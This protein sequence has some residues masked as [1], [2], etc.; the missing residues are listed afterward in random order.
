MKALFTI[1]F[2]L[3]VLLASSDGAYVVIND[4]QYPRD[5]TEIISLGGSEVI[6]G[7]LDQFAAT[8]GN[9]FFYVIMSSG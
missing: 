6:M 5:Y 8:K 9:D 3:S 7:E 4:G 1:Y 2:L